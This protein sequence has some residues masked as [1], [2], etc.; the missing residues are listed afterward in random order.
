[1]QEIFNL[2]GIQGLEGIDQAQGFLSLTVFTVLVQ[3]AAGMAIL[4]ALCP[5]SER[6]RALGKSGFGLWAFFAG[7]FV[8]IGT[9]VSLLHL[10]DPMRAP[11]ALSNPLE[12]WLSMEIYAV[13][14][15]GLTLLPCLFAKKYI[16]RLLCGLAATFVVFT[17]AQVYFLTNVS[18]W[19]SVNTYVTFYSTTLLL[20]AVGLLTTSLLMRKDKISVLSGILPKL[21]LFFLLVRMVSVA[22]LVLRAE[23]AGI[24]TNVPLMDIHITLTVLGAGFLLICMMQTSMKYMIRIMHGEKQL[25]GR[26]KTN[27]QNSLK[28]N[29]TDT[30]E[31]KNEDIKKNTEE[32]PNQKDGNNI[33][34]WQVD[35]KSSHA[36]HED[37]KNDDNK[38]EDKETLVYGENLIESKN[39]EKNDVHEL[40]EKEVLLKKES[41]LDEKNPSSCNNSKHACTHFIKMKKVTFTS[42]IMLGLVLLGELAGRFMFYLLYSNTGL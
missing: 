13:S 42:I 27:K 6:K 7:I 23:R 4:K 15:F 34:D 16:F 11:F 3:C 25:M 10:N 38:N 9:G 20:G 28:E 2:L 35:W 36:S 30:K 37:K 39:S 1:M 41:T 22:L 14:F 40:S 33:E 21:I 29:K 26:V 19:V 5:R 31:E 24:Q 17:M 12:S 32:K 18:A 8:L